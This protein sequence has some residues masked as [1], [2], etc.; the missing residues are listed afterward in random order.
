MYHSTH[1]Q[2]SA[3]RSAHV[4]PPE[5]R[6]AENGSLA[7][8]HFALAMRNCY[9]SGLKARD[10]PSRNSRFHYRSVTHASVAL[11]R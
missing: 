3:Q 8:F 5:G 10:P 11:I 6:Q 7:A 4:I 9:S 1:F 2:R